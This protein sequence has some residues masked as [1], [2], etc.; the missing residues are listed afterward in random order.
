MRTEMPLLVCVYD[1]CSLVWLIN[2]F[3]GRN[4]AYN[5]LILRLV[6]YGDE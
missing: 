5:I 2:Q 6:K 3:R 4:G 1:K